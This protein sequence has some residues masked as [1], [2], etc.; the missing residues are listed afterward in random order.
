MKDKK[1]LIG[2]YDKSLNEYV[3]ILNGFDENGYIVH[4]FDELDDEKLKNISLEYI[5]SDVIEGNI[6]NEAV[7]II[8]NNFEFLLEVYSKYSFKYNSFIY[9]NSILEKKH[10]SE[11]NK[12]K[13]YRYNNNFYFIN[14]DTNKLEN[15]SKVENYDLYSLTKNQVIN[16][17]NSAKE[18]F[19]SNE[20]GSYFYKIEN[21]ADRIKKY[22][23]NLELEEVNDFE[24]IF[25]KHPT[26][27]INNIL[28]RI[29]MNSFLL[30]TFKKKI[31]ADQLFEDVLKLNEEVGFF[32]MYQL[33]SKSF[34]DSRIANSLD[35]N[36]MDR[37]YEN[38][39]QK[40][41]NSIDGIEFIPKEERNEELVVVFISQFLT[42]EH[43][44]TKTALDRCY[45]LKKYLNKKV[46]LINTTELIT[47]KGLIPM[48]SISAGNI[49]ENYQNISTFN[50]KDI[51]IGY[52]QPRCS[53]PD[54]D[55]CKKI[56]DY[57]KREKPYLLLNIGGYSIAADLAAQIVPMATISTSGNFSISKNKGDFF[58]MGRK[59]EKSDYDLA[60]KLG[61]GK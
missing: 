45:V 44:P 3:D 9:D 12:M 50:Y 22:V 30:Y 27:I 2:F 47:S 25:K 21:K 35:G 37:L 28:Y 20:I 13:E 39:Y 34:T 54:I 6:E 42:M 17:I 41:K 52:Y 18:A 43:G 8:S 11:F 24:N 51:E 7:N 40:F 4:V 60:K 58:I 61:K 15:Y 19:I 1:I 57:I 36:I 29:Y 16:F 55:E 31:Y 46:V 59:A 14:K 56:I 49:I 33:I 48:N 32:V 26:H 5:L 23:Q 38:I 10:N 53:M